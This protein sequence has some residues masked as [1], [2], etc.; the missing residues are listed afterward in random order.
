[1]ALIT[2][3]AD[4]ATWPTVAL[5]AAERGDYPEGTLY[6]GCVPDPVSHP[7][8]DGVEMPFV[9][10]GDPMRWL[11]VR[12]FTNGRQH[13]FAYLV[14]RGHINSKGKRVKHEAGIYVH[15]VNPLEGAA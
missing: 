3:T 2:P 1:M 13:I 5:E 4:R 8:E 11:P 6:F 9:K 10:K 14:E 7:Y 15:P 12:H